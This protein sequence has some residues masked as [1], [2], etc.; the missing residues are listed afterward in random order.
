MVRETVAVETLALLATSLMFMQIHEEGVGET[1]M[2]AM[3]AG[4]R[5]R[6]AA[7]LSGL[8]LHEGDNRLHCKRLQK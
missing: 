7:S 2:I 4:L 5:N 6:G 1:Y 3:I 8:R